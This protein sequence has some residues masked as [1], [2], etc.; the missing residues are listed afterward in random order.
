MTRKRPYGEGYTTFGYNVTGDHEAE[1]KA[2]EEAR[3]PSHFG[4]WILRKLGY[5]GADPEPPLQAPHHGA[6]HHPKSHPPK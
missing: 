6:P 2:A 5:K 3:S 4:I 1:A